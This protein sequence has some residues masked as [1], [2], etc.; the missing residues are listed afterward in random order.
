[1]DNLE[2]IVHEIMEEDDAMVPI[3]LDAL[4]EEATTPRPAGGDVTIRRPKHTNF[5]NRALRANRAEEP[6][7]EAL[8]AEEETEEVSSQADIVF[9]S[10]TGDPILRDEN[11]EAPKKRKPSGKFRGFA[12]TVNGD[13]LTLQAFET[14]IAN[15]VSLGHIVY[16][17]IGWEIAPGTGRTHLQV[18][19]Y[20]ANAR[21]IMAIRKAY[22]GVHVEGAIATATINRNYCTKEGNF[23][24][25]GMF[26][27][28]ISL[29]ERMMLY[30]GVTE[31]N[32]KNI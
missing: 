20:F 21:S 4:L 22:P 10:L 9:S 32:I 2:A 26:P 12:I 24:E 16:A 6:M 5:P 8:P 13:L 14:E 19:L 1:M 30:A 31:I 25:Y 17:V 3:N 18:Y 27:D 15:S 7:P 28:A 29:F 23:T 11:G